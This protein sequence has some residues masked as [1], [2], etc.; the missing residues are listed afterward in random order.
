MHLGFSVRK[1]SKSDGDR[2]REIDRMRQVFR[3]LRPD[4]K[5]VKRCLLCTL[6][7]IGIGAVAV[8]MRIKIF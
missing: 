8:V 4:S 3:A 2:E 5:R 7:V 1:V 6:S